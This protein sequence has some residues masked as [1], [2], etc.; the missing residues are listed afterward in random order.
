[1]P[2]KIEYIAIPRLDFLA[3]LADFWAREPRLDGEISNSD[4]WVFLVIF[5]L[6]FNFNLNVIK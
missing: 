5:K 4:F 2:I 6:N 1:M 3:N